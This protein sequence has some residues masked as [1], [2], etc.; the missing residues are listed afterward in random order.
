MESFLGNFFEG[1]DWVVSFTNRSI[2]AFVKSS[3]QQ[4]SKV[5]LYFTESRFTKTYWGNSNMWMAGIEE[6]QMPPLISDMIYILKNVTIKMITAYW[7]QDDLG[8]SFANWVKKK[9][10]SD[11]NNIALLTIIEGIGMHFQKELPGFAMDLATSIPLLHWDVQRYATLH[12]NPTQALLEKQ[13]LLTFGI[14]NLHSRYEKGPA[15]EITLQEYVFSV[16]LRSDEALKQ[17]C[18][19]MLDYLYEIIDNRKENAAD[20]LQI[21]KMDAR[22]AEIEQIDENIIAISP[23][24]TGEAVK[25]VEQQKHAKDDEQLSLKIQEY[26]SN[27]GNSKTSKAL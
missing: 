13:I 12:K 21:Q 10:F 15:C 16:Q 27:K 5:Q 14:P 26:V 20:H 22:N 6:N 9:L 17:Q 18:H 8:V 19:Q 24:I 3:P 4:V 1:F 2:E 23:R 11:S 7:G 25:I